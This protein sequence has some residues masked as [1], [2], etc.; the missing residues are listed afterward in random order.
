METFFERYRSYPL[1]IDKWF[2]LQATVPSPD[3]LD[4]V[5]ALMDNAAFSIRNPNR[6]RALIGS[7]AA[8]NPVAFNRKDGAGYN[9][10]ADQVLELNKL[11]PQVAA[12]MLGAFRSWKTL[13]S[14]R[15]ALARKALERIAGAEGL[16]SDVADI[17]TRSLSDS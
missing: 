2:A 13:E 7:F 17:V 3:T 16:S 14:A 4:R 10:V 11:N 6:V 5:V 1:V 15:K 12:R 9:F 8:A